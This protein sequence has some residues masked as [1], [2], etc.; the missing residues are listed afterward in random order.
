[1]YL[2]LPSRYV[3]PFG[4]NIAAFNILANILPGSNLFSLHCKWYYAVLLDHIYLDLIIPCYVILNAHHTP[5][6]GTLQS[7][8]ILQRTNTVNDSV[9]ARLI[10]MVYNLFCNVRWFSDAR[11]TMKAT[12]SRNVLIET[13]SAKIFLRLNTLTNII[14]CLIYDFAKIQYIHYT[15]YF[16]LRSRWLCPIRIRGGSEIEE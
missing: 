13:G 11:K 15:S 2:L 8:E 16:S 1:M 5:R 14:L 12:A 7:K 10:S 6:V 9:H 3:T 4:Y